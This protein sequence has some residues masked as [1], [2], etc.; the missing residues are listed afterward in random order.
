MWKNSQAGWGIIAIF[1]H[2]VS[3]VVV[4]GLF[5]LGW[6]MTDLGYY[7][8]WY[9][10]APWIHRSLGVLLLGFI[11]LRLMWR[12]VQPTP[13]A[14]GKRWENIAAHAGHSLLYVLLMTVF[15][16]GYLMSTAKGS[17]IDVFG[18]FALPATL[19]GLPNQASLAGDIHWY[20]ALALIILASGHM[21]AA[22]KH[23]WIDRHAT[24]K[25][26]LDPRYSVRDK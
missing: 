19:H 12:L 1:M 14:Q 23:H 21:L 5:I 6:W 26:M 20:S 11:V 4:V 13:L 25:R 18:W 10:Q 16:S 8:P 15:V 24:L 2:W 22:F 9:N 17:P 7:D 3:A